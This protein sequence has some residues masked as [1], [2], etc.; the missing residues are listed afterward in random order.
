MYKC[1]C[2]TNVEQYV[3]QHLDPDATLRAWVAAWVGAWV[4][5]PRSLD[6]FRTAAHN[7]SKEFVAAMASD[8]DPLHAT[9][10]QI[11]Q[12][13][14]DVYEDRG[15]AQR[16]ETLTSLMMLGQMLNAQNPGLSKKEP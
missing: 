4:R 10:D 3:E 15:A 11:E 1:G 8:P 7:A 13:L 2:C 9:A 12:Y 16:R 5:E 6:E 14:V